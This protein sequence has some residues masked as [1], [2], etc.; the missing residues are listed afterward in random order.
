MSLFNMS[1]NGIEFDYLQHLKATDVYSKIINCGVEIPAIHFKPEWDVRVIPPFGGAMMRFTVEHGGKSISVYCDFF[2]ALGYFGG[3]YWE[4]YPRTYADVGAPYQDVM[5]FPLD[6]T[7]G[8]VENIDAELRG[9][10]VNE[11]GRR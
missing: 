10:A 8:L 6:D 2:D 5:R 3:P 4:M 9:E 1:W 11:G 7:R